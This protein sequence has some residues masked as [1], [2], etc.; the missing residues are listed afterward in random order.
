M[1]YDPAHLPD[2]A[3]QLK[4]IIVSLM[5]SNAESQN[6]INKLTD[7]LRRLTNLIEKFFGK[8][9][10]KLLKEKPSEDAPTTDGSV[11][12]RKKRKTNGGGGRNPLPEGLP[13]VE[14][15]IDVPEEERT[16][17]CCGELFKHIGDE[18]SSSTS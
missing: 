7:E 10:E 9:S 14:K 1:V 2:D 5:Q 4:A 12:E 17:S 6:T 8:S 15:V 13:Q 11:P 18:L 3:E 16:C